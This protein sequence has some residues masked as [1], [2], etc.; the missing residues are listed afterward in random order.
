MQSGERDHTLEIEAI[1]L[2]EKPIHVAQPMQ[3]IGDTHNAALAAEERRANDSIVENVHLMN[4]LVAQRQLREQ[5]E[6]ERDLIRQEAREKHAALLSAQAA[7]ERKNATITECIKTIGVLFALPPAGNPEQW[8]RTKHYLE[9]VVSLKSDLFLLH[10]HDAEVRAAIRNEVATQEFH[11]GFAAALEAN[12]DNNERLIS[13]V[14]KPLV[15]A[16]E[17]I[18]MQTVEPRCAKV[19]DAALAECK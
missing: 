6:Q 12:A 16:L 14:R 13:E 2:A 1:E 17:Q 18:A 19:A 3:D 5:A 7:I 11:K 9:A 4:R 15:E 8:E 10:Q